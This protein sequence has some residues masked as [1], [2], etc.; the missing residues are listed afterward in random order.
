M[1]IEG[2]DI[3]LNEDGSIEWTAKAAIDGDGT[4]P[5]FGDPDYQKETSLKLKGVSLNS[6]VDRYIVVPPAIIDA[7]K[8]IVLGCE[9]IVTYRG[10]S[11]T[12]VVGDIGPH[13]KLGE[14]SEACARALHIDPSPT[15]GGVPSG[16]HYRIWP[17]RPA[18]GYN[19]QATG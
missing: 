3:I 19:L 13:K 7:V 17:G 9:A 4:G 18:E 10:I 15:R 1:N 11:T 12:A 16:V 5:S 8:P 2:H 14:L 6:N